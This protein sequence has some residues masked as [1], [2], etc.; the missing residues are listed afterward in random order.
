VRPVLVADIL[1]LAR[2][3][4]TVTSAERTGVAERLVAE[5]QAADV[6]RQ[7]FGR[8][9]ASWGDGS[10]ASRCLLAGP[11][12]EPEPDEAAFLEAIAT[13]ANVVAKALCGHVCRRALV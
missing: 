7:K 6:F 4:Q 11:Q 3:L 5:A 8:S 2:V 10:I 9:H 13:A 1:A 12:P